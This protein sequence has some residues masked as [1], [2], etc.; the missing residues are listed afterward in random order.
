M[1]YCV[2][3]SLHRKTYSLPFWQFFKVNITKFGYNYKAIN[4]FIALGERLQLVGN[5][6]C[7]Q[8]EEWQ[9]YFHFAT[10]SLWLGGLFFY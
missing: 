3:Y 10:Y 4:E 1:Q 6:V 5:K 8:C 7:M 9:V 2:Y